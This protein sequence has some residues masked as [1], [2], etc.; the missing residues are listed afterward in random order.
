MTYSERK[1]TKVLLPSLMDEHYESAFNTV[2]CKA[3]YS[4][5]RPFEV[6]VKFEIHQ[7]IQ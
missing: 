4:N 5:F 2:D 7:P 1:T 3:F 6:D